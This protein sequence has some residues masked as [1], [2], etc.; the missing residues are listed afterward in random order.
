VDFDFS[1]LQKL[2]ASR[3][4]RKQGNHREYA[5]LALGFSFSENK[6]KRYIQ[7]ALSEGDA[8][9]CRQGVYYRLADASG[10]E[11]WVHTR[12]LGSVSGVDVFF[13]GETSTPFGLEEI[14]IDDE[15][16][17]L[18]G[19]FYG[20]SQP[21]TDSSSNPDYPFDGDFPTAFGVPDFARHLDL[22]LPALRTVQY[23]AF[24]KGLTAFLD[25]SDFDLRVPVK[26]SSRSFFPVD[27]LN[28]WVTFAGQILECGRRRNGLTGQE[29]DWAAVQAYGATLDIVANPRTVRGVLVPGGFV[30]GHF[31]LRGRLL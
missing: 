1:D 14:R 13:A 27:E 18:D 28:A 23:A 10:A 11:F 7:R 4:P 25:E 20:W 26:I 21:V 24:A 8:L 5:L 12:H 22:P 2:I 16:D 3:Y 31:W 19:G 15:T 6:L 17:P 29:F 30:M 9:A